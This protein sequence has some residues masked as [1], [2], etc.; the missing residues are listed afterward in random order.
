[1]KRFVGC[2]GGGG[3]AVIGPIREYTEPLNTC[4]FGDESPGLSFR[5]R[6]GTE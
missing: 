1:M 6:V 4:P 3:R 5:L 2:V